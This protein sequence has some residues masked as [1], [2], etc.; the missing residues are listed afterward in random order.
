MPDNTYINNFDVFYNES[1]K[2][3]DINSQ[4]ANAKDS[5]VVK[6]LISNYEKLQNS[7]V[8]EMKTVL[9]SIVADMNE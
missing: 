1:S 5:R 6:E 9:Q 8:A 4:L 7:E 2:L 3:D